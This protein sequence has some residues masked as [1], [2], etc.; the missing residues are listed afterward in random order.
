ME[1]DALTSVQVEEGQHLGHGSEWGASANGT[2]SL[3]ASY[4]LTPNGS[5]IVSPAAVAIQHTPPHLH[6]R[7]CVQQTVRVC[8]VHSGYIPH[9]WGG[10]GGWPGTL[11]HDT[12][13]G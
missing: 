9:T 8:V 1:A 13:S 12:H 2:S 7:T 3:V 4:W 10:G 11:A 6:H 5:H